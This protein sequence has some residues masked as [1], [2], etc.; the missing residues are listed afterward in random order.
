MEHCDT[1]LVIP[2][3][4]K[5]MLSLSDFNQWERNCSNRGMTRVSWPHLRI[6]YSI[7]VYNVFH[8]KYSNFNY[9]TS[10]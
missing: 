1:S 10:G 9:L 5:R 2:A 3:S 6:N 8:L 7:Q 4:S